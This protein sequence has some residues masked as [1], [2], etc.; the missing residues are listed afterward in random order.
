MEKKNENNWVND[1]AIDEKEAFEVASVTTI[2]VV[3]DIMT[4]GS[5]L[6]HS[7][8]IESIEDKRKLFNSMSG[9]GESVKENVNKTL[10]VVD[11]VV[12]PVE[13]LN[14]DGTKNVVPRTT[15]ILQDGSFCS[16]TSWGVYNSVKRMAAIFGSLHFEPA[17]R[18]VPVEVKTKN[19]FTINLRLV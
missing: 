3:S 6:Y 19:G 7:F 9:D 15:L 8:A 14:D 13:V 10:N 12:F 18:V 11:V 17:L 4:A 2:D 5:D 16:A 1:G